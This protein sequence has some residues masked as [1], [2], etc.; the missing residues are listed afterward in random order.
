[1]TTATPKPNPA[2]IAQ[3]L[4]RKATDALIAAATDIA[5][6][7]GRD[8]IGEAEALLT[9]LLRT[10][11]AVVNARTIV[12]RDERTGPKAAKGGRH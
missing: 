1:M 12:V 6:D 2:E 7:L 11:P 4:A 9:E 5:L 10:S 3:D 8:L